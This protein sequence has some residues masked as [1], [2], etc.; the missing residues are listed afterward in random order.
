MQA[1]L[2]TV[3]FQDSY[4]T[5]D[6]RQ[7]FSILGRRIHVI[8]FF[9]FIV[10]AAAILHVLFATP[11]FTAHGALYLGETQQEGPGAGD[12]NGTVNLSAYS[13]TSDV[14]TQIELLTTGTLIQRAILETG[15]NTSIKPS[16]TA[17][18]TYWR[19]RVLDGGSTQAFVPSP[20]ALQ[21]VNASLAGHYRLVTGP[22]NSYRL[23]TAGGIFRSSKPVLSGI[24]GRPAGTQGGTVLV[25]FA[26]PDPESQVSDAPAAALPATAHNIPAGLSYDVKI[27]SPAALAN[28]LE[29]GALSVNT[30]GEPTQ[31]TKLA[32]LQFRWSDPYQAKSFINQL[33]L[34]Y[35]ATQL[36]WKTEAASVTENFVSGQLAKVSQQLT[37]ADRK[38]SDYQAQTGIIDPQQ[39][40]QSAMAQM[41]A[42]QT[43]RASLLLQMQALQQLHDNFASKSGSANLFL[44]SQTNDTVLAALSTSL[45]Q[46]Q[47]KLSQL[48]TEFTGNAQDVKIQRAQ[49]NEISLSIRDLVNN[50][51]KSA[52]ENLANIDKLISN[53][54]DEL[55]AKP[56]ESLQVATLKRSSDQL[57]Q[58]YDLL[59][60]KAEQ[61]QISMAATIISTRIVTPSQLPLS[62]TS[63]R[64][65]ITVIAGALAGFIGGVML[66]LGQ[67]S[68]SGRFESEEQ[69]RRMVSLPVYGAVPR[70]S[71]ASTSSTAERTSL[72]LPGSFNPFSEAFHLIKRNISR[73]TNPESATKILVIS[74]NPQDGKTTIAANLAQSL[75]EDGKRVLLL[76][77]DVYASRLESPMDFSDLPGL[78]DWMN[79][80]KR[81]QLKKWPSGR[82]MVLP[83]GR[84]KRK[85]TTKLDETAIASIMQTLS[86]EF[87][88][89]ILDSPPLPVV[90]DGLMLGSFADLILSVI[91][92]SHTTRRAFE[93]HN[94][95]IDTLGKPRGLIIN[96]AQ[97]MNYGETYGYFYGSMKRHAKFFDRFRLNASQTDPS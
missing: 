18:L 31:P 44:V 71:L 53:Y 78:L 90:S 23:F 55:K 26:Q 9:T 59:T 17:R 65:M 47:A 66:V 75:A 50:D 92:V 20:N 36:Q 11:Q 84:T 2:P 38:L 33:M 12:A 61:A 94:E 5:V 73:Y 95:L 19:W 15:L 42:L 27:T 74:A 93:L 10:A 70:H 29:S 97:A 21:I 68:F 80:G 62:A 6:V 37:D 28:T 34:D 25:R 35:I 1:Q 72:T 16:N 96:G 57:G 14:E 69:I 45:S 8:L 64:A 3:R 81:P 48:T 89:L 41:S 86:N 83:A 40:A 13:T 82:F 85:Y 77:C 58:L 63:P 22:G 52:T 30:G 49:V 88:Y 76:N 4:E 54:K 67:H 79:T 56:A 87:D 91:N 24:I 46:A 60:Q 51:L 43:Q 7:L 32:T 39:N